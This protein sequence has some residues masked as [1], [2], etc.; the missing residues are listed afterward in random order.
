MGSF[1]ASA[2]EAEKETPSWTTTPSRYLGKSENDFVN[3]MQARLAMAGRTVGPFGLS[4]DP[5]KVTNI[6]LVKS[7]RKKIKKVVTPFS[8]VVNSIR[9]STV[10]IQER[11]F[12]VYT[13]TYRQGQ[14]FS[15]EVGNQRMT[16]RI[17]E[18]R[19]N[20]ITFTNLK[21]GETVKR[22]LD[23]VPGVTRGSGPMHVPGVT[24]AGGNAP[25]VMK[26]NLGGQ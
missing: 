22:K 10:N 9:V 6:P 8:D 17:D 3:A 2:E 15:V 7:P 26:I 5:N 23:L 20:A 11:S 1:A 16:V 25:K 14:E 4:Q 18:V 21:S 19:A 24:P 12:L 13:D